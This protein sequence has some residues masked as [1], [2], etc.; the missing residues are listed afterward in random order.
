MPT[1]TPFTNTLGLL[2]R[3]VLATACLSLC[4]PAALAQ[5]PEAGLPMARSLPDELARA[6]QHRQALVVMVS[7]DGCVFCRQARQSHLLPMHRAGTVIVQ[8]DMRSA[9]T[10]LDFAGQTTTHAQLTRSWKVSVTPT[11]LF[12]GPG[13]KEVAERMQGAYLPDFYGAYLDERMAQGRKA[14]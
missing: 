14:L 13:G 11:L 6:I 4:A 9:Q 3:D 8:V 10:V 12:W 2:R 1:R 7:Q 5:G